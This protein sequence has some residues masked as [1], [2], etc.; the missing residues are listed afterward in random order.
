MTIAWSPP[1]TDVPYAHPCVA[2]EAVALPIE[3]PAT[4]AIARGPAFKIARLVL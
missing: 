1:L 2:V 4:G 3:A